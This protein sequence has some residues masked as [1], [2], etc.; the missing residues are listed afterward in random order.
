MGYLL[1]RLLISLVA[2]MHMASKDRSL[3]KCERS[4]AE[5]SKVFSATNWKLILES[6]NSENMIF[7]I[8]FRF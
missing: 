3:C 6:I 5:P 7:S 4:Q 2:G 1:S 8:N